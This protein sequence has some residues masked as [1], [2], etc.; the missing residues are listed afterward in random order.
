MEN[1]IHTPE[2]MKKVY[3]ALLEEGIYGP[4]A[5]A[6]VTAMQNKGIL[7]REAQKGVRGV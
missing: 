6:V 7:F 3:E 5:F 2:T 4:Q 1:L